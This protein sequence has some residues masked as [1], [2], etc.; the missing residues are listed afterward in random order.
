MSCENLVSVVVVDDHP[1]TRH[2][3]ID[4]LSI[5]DH[6]WVLGEADNAVSAIREIT[7]LVPDIVLLDI[8][9]PGA[10]GLDICRTLQRKSLRSRVIILTSYENEDYIFDALRA[11]A[12]GYVLKIAGF[13]E[14]E[15]AILFVS[16]GVRTLSEPLI[17]ALVDQ[18][19]NIA[20]EKAILESG[21]D[22]EEL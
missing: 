9:L 1:I 14:L 8:R 11:G 4:M 10:S 22:I 16:R 6:I 17:N 13:V 12:W 15:Q 3:I 21:L 5:S 18:Y 2:G 19:S 20:R 7:N